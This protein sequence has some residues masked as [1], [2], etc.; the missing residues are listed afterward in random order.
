M[1]PEEFFFAADDQRRLRWL[2]RLD[3]ADLVLFAVQCA[4]CTRRQLTALN[5]APTT[6]AAAFLREWHQRGWAPQL[7]GQMPG[8]RQI[9]LTR[10]RQIAAHAERLG[11]THMIE[12]EV[13]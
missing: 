10:Q 7:A 11:L 4:D 9:W 5:P 12:Q 1:T 2:L 3:R 8:N 6:L 13:A